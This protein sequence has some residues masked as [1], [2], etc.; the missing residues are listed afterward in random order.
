[1]SGV[2]GADG[3]DWDMSVSGDA[4]RRDMWAGRIE[5]CL[6]SGTAIGERRSLSKSSLYKRSLSSVTRGL[7]A[8][9]G[10]TSG[11]VKATCDG[12]AAAKAIVPAL[13]VAGRAS[14]NRPRGRRDLGA[15]GAGNLSEFS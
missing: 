9:P 1:M 4:A 13:S 10:R 12:L 5:R 6:A 2:S 11:W 14:P 3:L 7:A 8:S 15:G